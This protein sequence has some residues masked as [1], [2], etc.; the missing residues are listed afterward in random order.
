MCGKRG[1]TMRDGRQLMVNMAA[2]FVIFAANI[3]IGLVLPPFVVSKIGAEGYGFAGLANT[4]IDYATLLTIA[5]NSV[6]SRF[7]AV[8]Y[9]RGDTVRARRYYSST[10]AADVIISAVIVAAGVP[11]IACLDRFIRIPGD[12]VG[13][14]KMLFA[15]VL[16]NFVISTVT[17]VC[18]VAA[19]VSNKLYL[20]SLASL[21]GMLVRLAALVALFG[22]LPPRIAYVGVA[23]CLAWGVTRTINL[24]CSRRLTP[25]L[26]FDRRAVSWPVVREM[27]ASGVWNS[28]VKLQQIMASGLKLLVANL[29]AGPYL[30]GMLSVAQTVPATLASMMI[31][32][33]SLFYPKQTQCYAQGRRGG[34]LAEL[35]SGMTVC[36]CFTNVIVVPVV[37]LGHD[38]LRLWQPGQDTALLYGLMV[39]ST[40]GFFVSG[41]ATTLHNLPLIV[42]RLKWYSIAWLVSS[43]ISLAA[44]LLLAGMLPRWSIYMIAAVQPVVDAVTNV[45]FVPVYAAACLG[46]ARSYFYPTYVRYASA[47]AVAMLAAAALRRLP[48][49][50]EPGWAMLLVMGA[51]CA[52][53][54]A[55]VEWFMLLG[56][57]DRARVVGMARGAARR[58]AGKRGMPGGLRPGPRSDRDE[59]G[60]ES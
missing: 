12:L 41:V 21:A 35:V 46:V 7:I 49:L 40:L 26:R 58:L 8:A 44:T 20:S 6:A 28:V 33:A 23:G 3:G 32:V 14:V 48:G 47:T 53:L 1:A 43:T 50:G 15:F 27:L 29:V 51:A 60:G 42:D 16:L 18:M 2:S 36:G 38:F 22:C 30:M 57:R 31:N 10:L 11:L 4:M 5:L 39:C 54:T 24:A 45:A 13:D 19:F 17:T 59:Q 25:D 55:A 37:V 52:C 56:R 34:L 9:H